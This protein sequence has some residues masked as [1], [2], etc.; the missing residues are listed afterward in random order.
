[1]KTRKVLCLLLAF[2]LILALAACGTPA[3]SPS[4]TASASAATT[5]PAASASASP[6]TSAPATESA[7][8]TDVA[9]TGDLPLAPVKTTIRLTTHQG[10]NSSIAMPGNELPLYQWIEEQT[11]VHIEWDT[12]P[13]D[14]YAETIN[15]RLASDFDLPDILNLHGLGNYASLAK[16]GIIIPQNDLIE[17]YAFYTQKVF[18]DNPGI[19]AL[20][21]QPDGNIY[22]IEDTII[23]SHLGVGMMINTYALERAGVAAM[24]TTIDDFY[25]ML[26]AMRDTDLNGN[27]QKDEVP[28]LTDKEA[29][30]MLSTAFGVQY[31]WGFNNWFGVSGST[32][33]NVYSLP[34][35]KDYIAFLRKLYAEDLMNKDY[36]TANWDSLAEGTA[37]GING[38]A[39]FWGTYA[40]MFGDISPDAQQFKDQ[41]LS[42]EQVPIFVPMDPLADASG[43]RNLLRRSGLNGDG[44]GIT[45]NCAEELQPLCMKWIDWLYASPESLTAQ[46]NGLE[47][48]SYT[49]NA[50]GTRNKIA[51]EGQEWGSYVTSLG[52]NQPPRA[53]Q[54]LIDGWRNSWLPDWLYEASEAQQHYYTESA[55]LP[56]PFT[57]DESAEIDLYA[58]DIDTCINENFAKFVNGSR[59]MDE[60]DAFVAEADAAGLAKLQPIYQARYER[61]K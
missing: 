15:V 11:N 1:M 25:N 6:E 36:A 57:P 40:Y 47:G 37:K 7:A 29:L 48:L 13:Y 26:V 5:A 16:D 44:M 42:G 56:I 10:T 51:P 38:V 35:M 24:P 43:N 61:Q 50:D 58:A 18:Q 17:E 12:V 39:G 30:R 8:P 9:Y 53:H 33:T 20:M 46:Y 34:G 22:C 55:L 2:V 31:T 23:D 28:M 3:P 4:A 60:W 49:L 52:G 27:G 45:T 21:Y 41:G 32:V 19:K 14:T 59:S 54:Q